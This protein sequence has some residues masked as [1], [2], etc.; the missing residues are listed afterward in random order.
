MHDFSL[1]W[2]SV[3]VLGIHSWRAGVQTSIL[4]PYLQFC[5]NPLNA[6][7]CSEQPLKDPASAV[8]EVAN[9]GAQVP[10]ASSS[11]LLT[12]PVGPTPW[13]LVPSPCPHPS[14][15]YTDS[16]LHRALPFLHIPPPRVS[17]VHF[18]PSFSFF[19]SYLLSY[20]LHCL[21]SYCSTELLLK[22]L[23]IWS[24]STPVSNGLC[25]SFF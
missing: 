18:W 6:L 16:C 25:F 3:S 5:C 21:L 9:S 24:M 20:L 23:I 8:L 22:F 13:L 2:C 4:S 12:Q 14:Q 15:Q 1:S 19:V 17:P 11:L 7:H 10:G